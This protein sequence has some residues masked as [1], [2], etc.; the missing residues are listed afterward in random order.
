MILRDFP[1]GHSAE[2]SICQCRGLEVD[3]WSGKIP[4]CRRAAKPMCHKY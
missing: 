3:P 2:E 1:G 4:Q